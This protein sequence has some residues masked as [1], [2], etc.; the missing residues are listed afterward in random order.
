MDK[1]KRDESEALYEYTQ[2]YIP[3]L[4]SYPSICLGIVF[5]LKQQAA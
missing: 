5:Y 2:R 4:R 3:L 1:D